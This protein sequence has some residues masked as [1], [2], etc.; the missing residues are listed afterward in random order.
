MT[1]RSVRRRPDL[2]VDPGGVPL[3]DVTLDALRAGTLGADE[4]RATPATLRL[5]AEVRSPPGGRSSRRASSARPSLR[6]FR[7]T[8]LLDVYTALRPRRATAAELE[9]WASRLEGYGAT[10]TAAFV[11][12]AA[13]A[14]ASGGCSPMASRR[15][16]SR[17][18]RD[19]HLEQLVSPLPELGSSR[20]TARTIPSRSSSSRA[21]R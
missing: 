18:A 5:Q 6:P 7:T 3:G 8:L 12:E 4:M 15:F 16:T 17:A 11:R 20:R 9:A 19:L 10:E 1:T 14:Y 2:V 21:A 13:A